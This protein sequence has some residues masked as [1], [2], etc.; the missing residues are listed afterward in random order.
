MISRCLFS[1]R[2]YKAHRGIALRRAAGVDAGVS[3]NF[4][5]YS[6]ELKPAGSGFAC[7]HSA[8]MCPLPDLEDEPSTNT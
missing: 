7:R 3:N 8:L 2:G 1:L 4:Q 6:T 5:I